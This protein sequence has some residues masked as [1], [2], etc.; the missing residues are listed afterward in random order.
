MQNKVSKLISLRFAESADLVI[1]EALAKLQDF[2]GASFNEVWEARSALLGMW[3]KCWSES[4]QRQYEG[5]AGEAW[6]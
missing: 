5:V 1:T 3:Y 2:E 4:Q 6:P